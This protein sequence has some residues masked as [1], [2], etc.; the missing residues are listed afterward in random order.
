MKK[1]I[2][3]YVIW[4]FAA[5]FAPL[6]FGQTIRIRVVDVQTG[7]P[8]KATISI[9]LLYDKSDKTPSQFDAVL[10]L[11][12]DEKGE[13]QF[14]LPEPAPAH[15][16]AQVHLATGHWHCACMVLASTQDLIQNGI[17]DSPSSDSRDSRNLVKA[18]PKEILFLIRPYTFFERILYPFLKQ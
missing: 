2:L 8:P 13:S 9:S 14:T 10:N 18:E 17:M 7:H 11:K 6:C 1:Q 16:A 15:L 5:G 4:V 3:R 12:T